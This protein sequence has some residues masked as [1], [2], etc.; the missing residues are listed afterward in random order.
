M[1]KTYI[2]KGYSAFVEFHK[3]REKRNM[4]IQDFTDMQEFESIISNWSKATG[5]AAVAVGTDGKYIS[6]RYNFTD[7]C[8][9]YTRGS[10]EGLM[11]CEK[12]DKTGKDVYHCHAGLIDFSI[13]LIVDEKKVGAVIGGQVLSANPDEAAFRKIAREIG[14][15]EEEYINALQKVNVRTEEAIRASVELLGQALNHFINAQYVKNKN[16][17]IASTLTKTIEE[18]NQL[19]SQIKEKTEGLNKIENQQKILALNA[20]IEAAR[21]GDVGR[22]FAIVASEFGKLSANSSVL[23]VEIRKIVENISE[24]VTKMHG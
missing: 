13:D 7:F 22:G 15:N 10:K 14:V 16:G 5:L 23:N 4:V 19:V 12:C 2:G 18:T 8:M 11:R 9:K 21:A 1:P 24:V 6:Q 17:N 20:N 3:K